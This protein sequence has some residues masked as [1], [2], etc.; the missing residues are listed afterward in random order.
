[1]WIT[2]EFAEIY[3][4]LGRFDSAFMCYNTLDTSKA[5]WKGLRIYLVSLGET[6]LMQ[7]EYQKALAN[8]RRAL[9]HNERLNDRSQVIRTELDISKS[10]IGLKEYKTALVYAR[11]ALKN[12][13]ETFARKSLMDAYELLYMSYDGLND[14][15]RANL[16]YRYFKEMKDSVA[17]DQLRG[18]LAASNYESQL[19]LLQ[20]DKIIAQQG[21]QLQKEKLE[22]ANLL[23][24]F[25]IVGIVLIIL[26]AGVLFRNFLLRRSRL[27]KDLQIQKLESK[28]IAGEMREKTSELEMAAM[29]AQMNP[30]F[31]FNCLNAI[32]HFILNN[33]S[34]LAS[35]YL[36]KFSRLIRLVLNSSSNKFVPLID[37]LTTLKIY[38]ELEQLRFRKHFDFV[39]YT[40]P[41]ID[42]ERTLLPPMLMQPFVENA[43]W[44]GLMHTSYKGMLRINIT[45]QDKVLRC[46]IE[47]NGIGRARSKSLKSKSASYKKSM[48]MDITRNRLKLLYDG[49]DKSQFMQITDLYDSDGNGSGTR[50]QLEIPLKFADDL[51]DSENSEI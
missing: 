17:A 37:E 46:V 14:P 29:R 5:G 13:K 26:L 7:K 19:A 41:D 45:Q 49:N 38:T 51:V 25:L 3:A 2:T 20:Q 31:I 28:K 50:V 10:Y 9:P 8:F 1:M 24:K 33:D 39:L 32:N 11:R 12:A 16:Y 6:F 15:Q 34:D 43:I 30:H 42:T 21:L 27:E 47:D 4:L 23:T 36:T 35:E 22:Q 44:H 40:D 18:R 48:G